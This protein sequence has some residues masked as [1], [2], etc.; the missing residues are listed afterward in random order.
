MPKKIELLAPAGNMECLVAAVQAGCDAVYLSGKAFGA[1][2]FAANFDNEE[3]L[4][5]VEYCHIHKVLVYVTVN[6]LVKQSEFSDLDTYLNYLTKINVDAVIV[7]DLGVIRYIKL[8]YPTL[9]VHASTQLNTFDI[10]G[11]KFLKQLGVSRVV[12]ARETSLDVVKMIAQEDIETEVFIHGALCFSSSGNCLMSSV[13]GGRSG[14]R[15]KCAQPCRKTYSLYEDNTLLVNNKALLS[16]KDLMTINDLGKLIEAN[17]TSLK[18]EGRMKSKEYVYTV[19]KAYREAI[20]EYYS[21]KQIT[22]STRVIN[23]LKLVFNRQ[24]TKGYIFNEPNFDI[25]NIDSVNHQ[26]IIIGKVINS[27]KEYI[28]V[29]LTNDISLHDGLR[30]LS[31]EEY[32]IYLTSIYVSNNQVK[33]ANAN[34]IVKLFVKN[35]SKP[36]DLVIKTSSEDLSKNIN[37]VLKNE[38]IKH[39]ISLDVSIFS[40]HPLKV[41]VKFDNQTFTVYGDNLEYSDDFLPIDRIKE[42]LSKLSSTVYEVDNIKIKTDEHAFVKISMLNQIRRSFVNELNNYLLSKKDKQLGLYNTSVIVDEIIK[43]FEIEAMVTTS[44]QDEICRQYNIKNIYKFNRDFGGRIVS[45]EYKLVH[46]IGQIHSN[47][48]VS[49]YLNI[50]NKEALM[51]L[52]DYNIHTCY[53]A[54]EIDLN[55]IKLLDLNKLNLN[56]GIMAYGR[57]DL[58]VSKHCIIGKVK[59]AS[60][61][62]CLSCDRHRY[63]IKDEFNNYYPLLLEKEADCTMRIL[64]DKVINL[65][66]Y[67]DILKEAGINRILLNFTT[68]NETEVK[69]ILDL[70]INKKQINGKIYTGFINNEIL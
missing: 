4:Q 57:L 53:L 14:N 1:R 63:K 30:V 70:F 44:Y 23:N 47:C 6:T 35:N 52:K 65:I 68:E 25:T 62:K 46:N 22:V 9:E 36:G 50:F 24:F 5:A 49:P 13:I 20:D 39:K 32:G 59:G 55:S 27:T 69:E 54:P 43:S 19:T 29:K 64:N 38:N 61:K 12:L 41:S 16:M 40:D 3:L 18:I 60:N 28:E 21:K 51:L 11:A 31:N 15:G 48:I 34:Q 37:E 2:S 10:N 45:N 26:G 33:K 7:Q 17:V 42:Q 66:N 67:L 8:N 58:M 56:V